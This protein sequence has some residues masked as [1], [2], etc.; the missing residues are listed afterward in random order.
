MKKFRREA[1][2]LKAKAIDSLRVALDAFNSFSEDTRQTKVLLHLQHAGEML[3]K[4]GLVQKNVNVF[5]KQTGKSK[6]FKTC[7]NLSGE[8]L[9]ATTEEQGAF[10]SVDGQRDVEQHW[11]IVISEDVLYLQTRL[12][13]TAFDDLLHRIFGERLADHLP[14]RVMPVSTTPLPADLVTL[15][16]RE[17]ACIKDLLKPGNRKRGEA[18]GRI[19]ELLTME[20][21]V[22]D[23]ELNERDVSRVEKGIKKGKQF[24]AIFPRL[25]NLGANVSGSGPEIRV[26]ISKRDGIP[27]KVVKGDEA[28]S[29]FAVR[30]VDLQ[31]RFKYSSSALAEKVGLTGPRCVA[32]REHLKIDADI[33][34]AHVFRFGSQELKR[35]SD[36]AL[37]RLQQARKT[38]DMVDVWNKYL[39][40]TARKRR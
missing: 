33:E 6:G 34:C 12:F 37:E 25:A 26:T 36:K 2:L 39:L 20:G 9:H 32:L 18:L 8:H 1:T 35:F 5:D 7:L 10:R 14:A 19:R 29:A 17:Y 31:N 3:L 40:K 15:F 30:E 23:F 22:A 21:H 13:L 4:A 24:A 11:L 38:V 16:D 28:T 27:V